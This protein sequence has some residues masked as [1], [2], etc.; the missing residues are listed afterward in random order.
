VNSQSQQI[1]VRDLPMC[2]DRINPEL[3]STKMG[4]MGRTL[5]LP[6]K[7]SKFVLPKNGK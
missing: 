7:A 6:Y 3:S 2:D 1:Y 5:S 4:I